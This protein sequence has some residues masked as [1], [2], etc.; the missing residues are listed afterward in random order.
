MNPKVNILILNW[1]GSKYLVDLIQSIKANHYTNYKITLIDNNSTDNSLNKIKNEKLDIISHKN[2]Y[3]YAKGYNKAIF[4]LKNDDSEFLLLLN[5]DTICDKNI[6]TSF[7]HALKDYGDNCLMGAKILYVND[8][9]KIWYAGGKF[10][11]LNSFVSHRGIRK[12]DNSN[13]DNDC[14][15]DYITG[16]CLFISKK[17]FLK[18]NGFDEKFNMYGEDVD[19]SIRAQNLG[20]KCYYISNARL[21]HYV[22]ASYG[23]NFNL[24]KIITKISSLFKLMIKYPKRIILGLK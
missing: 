6:L 19:L 5:N 23:G 18:L 24:V 7:L 3:K 21:W 2:N 4:E 1:N 16:C 8:K 10:G 14:I 11:L 22:S 17:N 15:T 20:I 12:K 9:K 13:F